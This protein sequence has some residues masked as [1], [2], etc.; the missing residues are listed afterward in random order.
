MLFWYVWTVWKYYHMLASVFTRISHSLILVVSR[1]VQNECSPA[2]GN[3]SLSASM[4]L[5]VLDGR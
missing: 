5:T 3:I 1:T 2:T 4:V